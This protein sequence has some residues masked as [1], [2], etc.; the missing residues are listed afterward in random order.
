MASARICLASFV[1]T[2]WLAVPGGVTAPNGLYGLVMKGPIV[3]VCRAGEPCDGPAQVTL[4]FSRTS[5]AGVTKRWAVRS[6]ASG[7]Y[8]IALPAGYY[9]VTTKERIGIDRNIRP[10]RVQVRA[11]RWDR[12][13]FYIDTGIR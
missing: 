9:S 8:R 7:S 4:Y 6:K 13:G 5:A 10:R 2:V 11:G 12:I 3:P 1:G